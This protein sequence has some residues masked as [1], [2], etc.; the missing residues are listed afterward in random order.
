MRIYSGGGAS[1]EKG[2]RSRTP[3]WCWVARES[4]DTEK[5]LSEPVDNSA[6]S[7]QRATVS[8][9]W[10]KVFD[11]TVDNASEFAYVR[12]RQTVVSSS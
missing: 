1:H 7:L 3:S 9:T 4:A 11:L 5:G 10:C 2:E 8:Q 6:R 12:G